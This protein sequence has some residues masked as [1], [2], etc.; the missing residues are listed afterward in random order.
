MV[1]Q[2][3]PAPLDRVV[4]AMV[5]W[6]IGETHCHLILLHKI[7]EPLHELRAPTMVLRAIIDIE[8]Q[9]G[10]VCKPL[11]DGLPP[12][13]EPVYQAVTGHFGGDPVHKQFIPCREKDAHRSEGRCWMKIVVDR[14]D[15]GA[16]FAP[17]REGTH[18]D[19]GFRIHGEA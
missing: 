19:G 10:N 8:Y 13:H 7:D 14:R 12:L 18:F 17:T 5:W 9:R 3:A 1:L 2:D 4:F 11:A 15:V 6:I 16:T